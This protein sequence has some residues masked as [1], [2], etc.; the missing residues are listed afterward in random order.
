MIVLLSQ[1]GLVSGTISTGIDI[2]SDWK[3]DCISI[4]NVIE[5]C[6]NKNGFQF[7]INHDF[8]CD[9]VENPSSIVDSPYVIEDGG[10]FKDFNNFSISDKN[11]YFNKIFTVGSMDNNGNQV[12]TINGSLT[13][14]NSRQNLVFGTGVSGKI[15]RDI[16]NTEF[17]EYTAETTTS[18]TNLKITGHPF[19]IGDYIYNWDRE[20]GTFVTAIVDVNNVTVESVSG[21]VIDDL[22]IYYTSSQLMSNN[23][24]KKCLYS[25]KII[26][27][28]TNTLG[29]E[30]RQKLKIQLSKF[31]ID[32]Y[33]YYNIENVDVISNESGLYK[34]DVIASLRNNSDFSTQGTINIG[35]GFFEKL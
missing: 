35:K 17:T 14:Q 16:T 27:F 9:F 28:S 10:I 1:E 34:I 7:I 30:V 15:N 20:Q 22:I 12:F 24:L 5:I 3:N 18:S 33:E 26:K 11:T 6:C 13:E 4:W 29:F 2:E 31:N 25:N 19:S 32:S 23:E 21:Q 8:T